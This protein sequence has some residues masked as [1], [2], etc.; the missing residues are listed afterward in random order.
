MGNA[1]TQT[2]LPALWPFHPEPPAARPAGWRRGVVAQAE[3]R[4]GAGS[5]IRR[6]APGGTGASLRDRGPRLGKEKWCAEPEGAPA[7]GP[8]LCFPPGRARSALTPRPAPAPPP[9]PCGPGPARPGAGR[10]PCW[11]WAARGCA[12]PARSPGPPRGPAPGTSKCGAP[13]RPQDG[14]ATSSAQGPRRHPDTALRRGCAAPGSPRGA[15]PAGS[16]VR[17][18]SRGPH[19]RSVPQSRGTR[20]LLPGPPGDPGARGFPPSL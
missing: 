11:P 6:A 17:A 18:G 7:T 9:A 4:S 20:T 1:A 16:V 19:R 12:T 2:L 5:E 13:L 10:W 8:S 14:E 15:P 3:S